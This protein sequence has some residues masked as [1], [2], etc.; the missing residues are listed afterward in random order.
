MEGRGS[1]GEGDDP[2]VAARPL[3]AWATL[4]PLSA[5]RRADSLLTEEEEKAKNG[6]DQV[7]DSGESSVD[8]RPPGPGRHN[9]VSSPA[10]ALPEPPFWGLP[11]S[12]RAAHLSLETGN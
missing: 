9:G 4:V 1:E 10:Q 3:P 5:C 2:S 6:S 8:G 12:T 11:G 7:V